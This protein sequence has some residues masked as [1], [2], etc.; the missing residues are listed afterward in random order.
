MSYTRARALHRRQVEPRQR[1]RWRGCAQSRD[2][3]AARTPAARNREGSRRGARRRGSR[4]QGVEGEVR[5]RP[6]PHHQEGRRPLARAR[7]PGRARDDAGTGQDLDR[8]K[9]RGRHVRRHRRV[10]RRG[11]KARLRPGH[12]EPQSDR[13]PD[14]RHRAGRRRRGVHAMEFPGAHAGSQ[15]CGG[16][17]SR[18]R[19]HHQGVGS[20]RPAPA[21]N[22]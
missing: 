4:L 19:D 7:R 21:S 12:P 22:W 16:A 6:Q 8:G 13:A 9:G 20:R 11:R 5:L 1:R 15:G 17:R 3:E 18:L 14:G 10:V 2:A